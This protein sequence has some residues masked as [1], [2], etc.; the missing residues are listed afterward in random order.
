MI[1]ANYI[2][3][4]RFNGYGDLFAMSEILLED[5]IFS[6]IKKELR[7]AKRRLGI[8]DVNNRKSDSDDDTISSDS[9]YDN[10]KIPLDA[11]FGTR[12]SQYLDSLFP[13]QTRL[14]SMIT[15]ELRKLVKT[16]NDKELTRAVEKVRDIVLKEKHKFLDSVEK[17]IASV[18]INKR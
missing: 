11:E 9:N 5:N 16:G 1:I 13:N 18:L 8:N 17:K 4:N 12:L 15:Y 6:D 14:K 10:G 2:T 3:I 7:N